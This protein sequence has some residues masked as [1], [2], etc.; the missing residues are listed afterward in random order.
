FNIIY[1]I[2]GILFI[3]A[4]LILLVGTIRLFALVGDGTLSPLHPTKYIVSEGVYRHV[5]NPMIIG[6]LL[7]LLGESIIF[8]S[9]FLFGWFLFFFT[10]NHV[11]FIKS[12]EPGLVK[13]FGDGYLIYKENVPRWIPRKTPW[14][15]PIP[16]SDDQAP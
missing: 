4:G 1:F 9:V 10:G 5:R 7:I 2:T 12:E 16:A 15:P 8:Y 11:Y 3:V 13:R 6:V 14:S